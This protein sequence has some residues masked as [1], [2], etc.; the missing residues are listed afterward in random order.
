MSAAWRAGQGA[1]G[2]R[3]LVAHLHSACE[4]PQAL[5][6]QDGARRLYHARVSQRLARARSAALRDGRGDLR[7]PR[8]ARRN[9]G[10]LLRSG[11]ARDGGDADGAAHADRTAHANGA[12]HADG[13]ALCAD[14]LQVLSLQASLEDVE[15]IGGRRGKH[16]RARACGE[17]CA[18]RVRAFRVELLTKRLVGRAHNQSIRHIH[19]QRR[20]V[21][22]QLRRSRATSGRRQKGQQSTQEDERMCSSYGEYGAWARGRVG[23]WACGR[24]GAWA[25]RR[26][27]ASARD[28]VGAC[29]MPGPHTRA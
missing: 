7:S 17:V 25:H 21:R 27:D 4:A 2:R 23:V 14:H 16:P 24:I 29:T 8:L 12:A 26:E 28:R 9:P 5:L 10:A 11:G 20:R 19:Q 1:S 22:E 3:A 15:R 13:A 18:Q 6:P